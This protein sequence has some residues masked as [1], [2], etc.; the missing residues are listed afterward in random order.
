M[1]G[2]PPEKGA[3]SKF[4]KHTKVGCNKRLALTYACNQPGDVPPLPLKEYA[5]STGKHGGFGIAKNLILERPPTGP[6]EVVRGG[7]L[8]KVAGPVLGVLLEPTEAGAGS[9]IIPPKRKKE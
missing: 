5:R 8:G 4:E 6:P 2:K 1:K 9:D 3:L 7:V